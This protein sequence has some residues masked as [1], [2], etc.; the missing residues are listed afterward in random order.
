MPDKRSFTII[1]VTSKGKS[2]G[3]SNLGGRYLSSTPSGSARKAGSQ[4]CRNSKMKGQCSLVITIKE[5]TR[6][7]SGKEFKYSFKRVKLNN[8]EPVMRG[9]E[10]IFYK[11]TTKVKSMK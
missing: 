7:S 10:E 11:Y 8:P 3:K 2:K 4:V 5:T 9:D 1:L 6:N